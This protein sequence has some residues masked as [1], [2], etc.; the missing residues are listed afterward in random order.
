[1]FSNAVFELDFLGDGHAVLGDG[2]AAE[3]LVD[4]H[5]RP[6]GPIVMA[7]ASASLSTPREHLGSG[8]I[9]EQQLLCHGDDS[10]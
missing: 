6:V 4:D 7:T 5:V 2:R 3:G 10:S 1:M 9:V 8:A